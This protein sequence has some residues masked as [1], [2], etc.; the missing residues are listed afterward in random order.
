[1]LAARRRRGSTLI[2]AYHNIVPDDAPPAGDRSL[3]LPL[4]RF[5]SQIDRLQETHDVVDLAEVRRAPAISK[6]PR[7]AITFDDAYRGAL[8]L[9]LPELARRGLPATVF[10]APGIL[11]STGCWWDLLA[12]PDGSGLS[13]IV[14]NHVLQVL[15]GDGSAAVAWARSQGMPLAALPAHA[16]I[17]TEDELHIAAALPGIKLG[18]HTWSHCNLATVSDAELDGELVGPLTWLRER[19]ERV[20]PWLAYP[21][22][23][24]A[25]QT[26]E[27]AQRAAYDGAL[28][29]EGGWLAPGPAA[30]FVLPRLNVPAGLSP[31]G[32]ILRASGLISS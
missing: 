3:H 32:F 4:A 28:R 25:P 17:A 10:V 24:S 14:R 20:V 29:I 5:R 13:P 30:A 15:R 6:R 9:A 12:A 8:G 2:L 7:V 22:G 19:F 27:R 26:P 1:M 21:Y 23:L 11:G 18:V 16:A 31:D